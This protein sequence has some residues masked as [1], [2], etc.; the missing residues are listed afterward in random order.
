[1]LTIS[2][3]ASAVTPRTIAPGYGATVSQMAEVERVRLEPKSGGEPTGL[4]LVGVRDH[5]PSR[6]ESGVML[7]GSCP[8][9]ATLAGLDAVPNSSL[10]EI[11]VFGSTIIA[12]QNHL[13]RLAPPL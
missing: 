13:T 10:D 2:R 7:A 6:P 9:P 3:R 1:M 5:W 12:C 8:D 4:G 11:R